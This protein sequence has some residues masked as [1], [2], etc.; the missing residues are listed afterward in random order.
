MRGGQTTAPDDGVD[1]DDER[2]ERALDVQEPFS[3]V[4]VD[5]D[6]VDQFASRSGEVDSHFE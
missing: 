6:V 1:V 5:E 3:D 2:G 4:H